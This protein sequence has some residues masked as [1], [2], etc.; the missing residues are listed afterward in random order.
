[1]WDWYRM[2]RELVAKADPNAAHYALARLERLV[3]QFTLITQ[4]V[5]DLHR[6]AGSHAV[7]A[8]HGDITRARC[9]REGTVVERWD[10]VKDA[11]P[12]CQECGAWLRPDVV[13]FGELLPEEALRR[14]RQAAAECDVFLSVGTSNLVE[15]AASLPWLAVS[16]GAT[17]AVVNPSMEGQESGP[18]IFPLVGRAGDLLPALVAAGWPETQGGVP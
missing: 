8:L 6:R 2:R 5:D 15:P 4:N 18:R 10:E 3:P 9:S 7:L 12:R 14:A 1:V 16:R 13:W 17:V 11:P